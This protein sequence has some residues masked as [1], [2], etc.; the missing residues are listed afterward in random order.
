MKNLVKVKAIT[1]LVLIGLFIVIFVS[2]I[3]LSIA[4]SGKIARVTGWEFIG[5]SKQLLSTI[6]TWF[7]YI[8]GALIVFHFVLN[9]KLFACEI[10]NLF[11]GENKNFSLK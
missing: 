2:S 5:F 3:G 7:G 10:R 11:R 9:Y 8:L 6:H 4:P 1:S